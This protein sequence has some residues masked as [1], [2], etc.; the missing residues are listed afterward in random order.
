MVLFFVVMCVLFA[1]MSI[2]GILLEK[3]KEIDNQ[4]LDKRDCL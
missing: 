3:C 2:S 4:R 1:A